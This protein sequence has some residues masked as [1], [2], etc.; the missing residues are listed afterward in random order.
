MISLNGDQL[1]LVNAAFARV[2]KSDD[3][4]FSDADLDIIAKECDSEITVYDAGPYGNKTRY[5]RFFFGDDILDLVVGPT[6][7]AK[8]KDDRPEGDGPSP[9]Q[10]GAGVETRLAA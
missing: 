7:I 3:N 9:G 5:L 1:A 4:K 2:A 8:T 10:P 6:P